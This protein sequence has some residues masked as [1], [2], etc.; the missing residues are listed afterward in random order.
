MA[1]HFEKVQKFKFSIVDV[2]DNAGQG[3]MIGEAEVMMG[4]LMGA[5]RQ[6]WTSDLVHAGK[7]NRGQIIVRTQTIEHSNFEAKW[8]LRW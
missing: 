1:Y 8:A 2:D 6:T 5:A 3:D 7:K 4:S